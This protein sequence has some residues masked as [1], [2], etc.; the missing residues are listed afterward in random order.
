[1]SPRCRAA[2]LRT[3]DKDNGAFEANMA[4]LE[5]RANA[6]LW[7]DDYVIKL[8]VIRRLQHPGNFTDRAAFDQLRAAGLTAIASD[9]ID[10][11]RRVLVGLMAIEKPDSVD[12][13]EQ[14]MEQVNVV[15]K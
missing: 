7:K 6:L 11:L 10:E 13:A 15:R 8:N 4:E 3:V 5:T 9:N 12:G 1:M 2:A 14:M